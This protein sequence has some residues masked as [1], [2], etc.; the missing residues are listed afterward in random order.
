MRDSSKTPQNISIVSIGAFEM[1]FSCTG[2]LHSQIG[3]NIV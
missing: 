3:W 1:H 2:K